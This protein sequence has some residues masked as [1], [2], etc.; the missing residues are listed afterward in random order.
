MISSKTALPIRLTELKIVG[1]NYDNE[2]RM[3]L[4][5]ILIA[6]FL[7]VAHIAMI[8]GMANPTLI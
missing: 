1:K 2:K 4:H 7:V 8:L 3:Q 5:F 6:G